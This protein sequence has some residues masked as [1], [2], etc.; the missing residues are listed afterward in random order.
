L[1]FGREGLGPV[2]FG[3]SA[4]DELRSAGQPMHRLGRSFTYCV[5]GG[6]SVRVTFDKR[7]KAD[8]ISYRVGRRVRTQTRRGARAGRS[9][10]VRL[11]PR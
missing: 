1:R 6:G 5:K 10:S 7:G 9:A 8:R 11:L 4:E 2:A 3:I